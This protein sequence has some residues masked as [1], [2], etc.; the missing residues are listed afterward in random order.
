MC[1][2]WPPVS[3][4]WGHKTGSTG[5]DTL[6]GL[7]SSGSLHRNMLSRL[8]RGRHTQ[9]FAAKNPAPVHCLLHKIRIFLIKEF[10]LS[11]SCEYKLCEHIK[12]ERQNYYMKMWEITHLGAFSLPIFMLSLAMEVSKVPISTWHWAS[13]AGEGSGGSAPPGGPFWGAH[14]VR[15]MALRARCAPGPW[16]SQGTSRPFCSWNKHGGIFLLIW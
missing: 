10:Q 3:S 12:V 13:S 11:Y 4:L 6:E 5:L 16:S 9:P 15:V 8:V 1:L 14:S 2:F 7:M